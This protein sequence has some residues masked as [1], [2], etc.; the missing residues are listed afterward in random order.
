MTREQV[1]ALA[2]RWIESWNARDV[3]GVL[4]YFDDSV[5]FTSPRAAEITGRSVVE[6]KPALR[7]YWVEA[8]ARLGSLRFTLDRVLWDEGERTMVFVYLAERNGRRHR[9]CEILRFGESGR[10]IEGEAMHGAPV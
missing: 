10:A 2:H 1:S 6:G 3:E 9:A 5:R 7:A 8:L 4:S